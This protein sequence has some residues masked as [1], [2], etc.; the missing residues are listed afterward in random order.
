VFE[1][2]TDLRGNGNGGHI[3]GTDLSAE[4]KGQLIEYLKTL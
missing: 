3:Y 1:F 2:R 4:E